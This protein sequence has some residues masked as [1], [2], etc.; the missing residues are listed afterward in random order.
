L[1]TRWRRV[2][3][4]SLTVIA[5]AFAGLAVAAWGALQQIERMAIDLDGARERLGVDHDYAPRPGAGGDDRGRRDTGDRASDP[6]QSLVDPDAGQARPFDPRDDSLDVFLIVGVDAAGADGGSRADVILLGI[7]PA[8]GG[9]PAL[10]SLPRDLW[11]EDL[12]RGGNQRI[13]A[14][15]LGCGEQA[16]G[17]ELMILTV[18]R[19]TGLPVDHYAEV[20]FDGF[21][22]VIDIVGG[23]EICTDH[24][25]RDERSGLSMPAGCVQA[26]GS[27]ALAWVRSRTTEEYVDGTW[28]RVPD[29][30][31]LT[32]N[33]RQQEVLLDVAEEVA[34][35]RSARR[36]RAL[37]ARAAEEVVLG[38]SL[39]SELLARTMWNWRGTE[40]DDVRRA[41]LE[42]EH[43]TTDA[44]AAVLLP[45]QEFAELLDELGIED[46]EG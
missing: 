42:V 7:L 16:T 19:F 9:D 29:V 14:A 23:V 21:A 11:I 41:S 25:V 26:D 8:D 40:R 30:D 12:C 45:V 37:A 13:N 18:E 10:V 36:L 1:A 15:L 22:S 39:S 5:L 35:T 4:V 27:Q 3:V 34:A 6:D 28:Q 17:Q 46:P 44:G 31:D 24:A 33:E 2:L 38:E 20:D 32:R 43:H